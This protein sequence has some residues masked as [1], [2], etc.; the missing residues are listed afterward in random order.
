MTDDQTADADHLLLSQ[1][2][3]TLK[4]RT[5]NHRHIKLYNVDIVIINMGFTTCARTASQMKTSTVIKSI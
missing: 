4:V 2:M 1:P 3:H 5:C